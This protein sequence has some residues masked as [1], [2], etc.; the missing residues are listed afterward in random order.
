MVSPEMQKLAEERAA[1]MQ[2]A[3]ELKEPD[4]VPFTG[5][6]GDVIA[7]Y[8]GITAY[9]YQFDFEKS[10]AAVLKWLKGCSFLRFP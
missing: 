9:E 1:R 2:A 3:R 10:R 6:G 4:R 8:A 7:A 5:L